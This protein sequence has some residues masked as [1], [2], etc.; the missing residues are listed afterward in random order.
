M[1]S[2]TSASLS[3][4]SHISKMQYPV[5]LESVPLV[6]AC[7]YSLEET[8][9]FA[10]LKRSICFVFSFYENYFIFFFK[11]K[12]LFCLL[13]LIDF[14]K[15]RYVAD[16]ESERERKQERRPCVVLCIVC[17]CVYMHTQRGAESSYSREWPSAKIL[18]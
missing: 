13:F 14:N 11:G 3:P 1:C 2:Y 17:V 16:F 6:H 12:F 8:I 9:T 5:L 10:S 15:F 7:S 4:H 18:K